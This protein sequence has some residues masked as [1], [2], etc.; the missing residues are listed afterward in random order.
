MLSYRDRL[1]RM[2]AT[3]RPYLYSEFEKYV[4]YKNRYVQSQECR[5]FLAFVLSSSEKRRVTMPK[6]SILWRAQVAHDEK[7][8]FYVVGSRSVIQMTNRTPA[9]AKRM[10]PLTD[11]AQEGRANPK[12]IPCLYCA[13]EM[14]TA[15]SEVRPWVGSYVTVGGFKLRSEVTII[16]CTLDLENDSPFGKGEDTR[17]STREQ[18]IWT[19]IN[20]AFSEPVTRSDD[21][22][23]YAPTQVIAESFK[24][25]SGVGG[26]MYASKLGSGKTLAL[27]DVSAAA[28]H[29]CSLFQIEEIEFKY[30]TASVPYFV[31]PDG[32]K[33]KPS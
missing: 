9:D 8:E 10:M 3:V 6:D 14:D 13:T 5:E 31:T 27:F 19:Q 22:G 32:L 4:K 25:T 21:L 23:D 2:T 17:S 12:G 28:M 1:D 18:S 11:R 26:L 33:L 24:G 7:R 29:T 30:K 15:I 16:D 20:R